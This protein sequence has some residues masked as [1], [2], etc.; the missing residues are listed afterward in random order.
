MNLH[1][2][3]SIPSEQQIFCSEMASYIRNMEFSRLE[4][5]I[6]E[7]NASNPSSF[8][9]YCS[10]SVSDIKLEGWDNIISDIVKLRNDKKEVTAI[11]INI[12][13]Y[14]E[15]DGAYFENSYYDDK[16]FPFSTCSRLDI[17]EKAKANSTPWQ[18]N[19]LDGESH[20]RCPTLDAAFHAVQNYPYRHEGPIKN[21]DGEWVLPPEF[22][23]FTLCVWFLYLRLNQVIQRD[24][25]EIGLPIIMPVIVGQHG[26]GPI[27]DAVYMSGKS[28]NYQEIADKKLKE[29]DEASKKRFLAEIDERISEY[30]D[31]RANCIEFSRDHRSKMAESYIDFSECREENELKRLEILLPCPSWKLPQSAFEEF[32]IEFRN[33]RI[34]KTPSGKAF[35]PDGIPD[36][37]YKKQEPPHLSIRQRIFG[38][39]AS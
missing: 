19:F 35:F 4:E 26:F 33:Q 31:I 3:L 28:Q 18:G 13:G 24:V 17:A 5:I 2:R 20:L 37:Y 27:F 39:K 32:L 34:A 23:G 16:S 22:I 1:G 10:S 25:Q 38:R 11:S 7:G 30:R 8:K 29:Q 9:K 15:G 6:R 21:Q 36:N 14:G 12:S